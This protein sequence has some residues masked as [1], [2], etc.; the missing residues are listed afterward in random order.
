MSE[1]IEFSSDPKPSTS[2]LW[3]LERAQES[4]L[5]GELTPRDRMQLQEELKAAIKELRERGEMPVTQVHPVEDLLSKDAIEQVYRETLEAL[6]AAT[7][8]FLKAFV[9]GAPIKVITELGDRES[10]LIA[11]FLE[12]TKKYP[13]LDPYN[14]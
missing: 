12:M 11:Q 4:A 3:T 5:Q 2:L 8:A 1:S 14:R 7:D 9:E 13:W 6:E 10:E